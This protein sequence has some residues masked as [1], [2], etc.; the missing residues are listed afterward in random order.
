M[1]SIDT[2]KEMYVWHKLRGQID[3]DKVQEF[4]TDIGVLRVYVHSAEE[5]D[6]CMSIYELRISHRHLNTMDVEVAKERALSDFH[7]ALYLLSER[8]EKSKVGM[9]AMLEELEG[10]KDSYLSKVQRDNASYK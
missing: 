10:V 5:P 2:S 9:N 3:P 4:Y 1:K 7:A 8:I 6:Y